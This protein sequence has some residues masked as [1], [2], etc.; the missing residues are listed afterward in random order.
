MGYYC[1]AVTLLCSCL[2]LEF[3]TSDPVAAGLTLALLSHADALPKKSS[4][5]RFSP[6]NLISTLISWLQICCYT[7]PLIH[8][9]AE[10]GMIDLSDAAKCSGSISQMFF[11]CH[12][13]HGEGLDKVTSLQGRKH[14][15]EVKADQLSPKG[16]MLYYVLAL[17]FSLD[18]SGH[19]MS[20]CFSL[21]FS[22][23]YIHPPLQASKHHEYYFNSEHHSLRDSPDNI[24][25][26]S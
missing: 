12:R 7:A 18:L 16:S 13:Y 8:R 10:D 25:K 20:F 1:L 26:S 5:I 11:F 9:T 19:Q 14:E 17:D 3:L 6:Q 22:F 2:S 15:H 23:S 24:S 21:S 4:E